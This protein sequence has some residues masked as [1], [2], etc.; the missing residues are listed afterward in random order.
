MQF[1]AGGLMHP[2]SITTLYGAP[3]IGKGWVSVWAYLQLIFEGYNPLILDFEGVQDE[4]WRRFRSMG[5][6]EPVAY[7]EPDSYFTTPYAANIIETVRHNEFTHVIIDSASAARPKLSDN[8]AGGS[9]ATIAMFKS[10]K[11]IDVPI[12]LIAHE[13]KQ[14]N[15]PIGSIHFRS[16]SRLV[17]Q[18][19]AIPNGLELRMT[20]ANDVPMSNVPVSFYL[21]D[22][23]IQR[24]NEVVEKV[25]APTVTESLIN[26]MSPSRSWSAEQMQRRLTEEGFDVS[27][28]KVASLMRKMYMDGK[29]IRVGRGRYAI[30]PE[31]DT[32]N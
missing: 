28:S 20:K 13:G 2:E 16:Q 7:I 31:G 10:L 14:A 9:D 21:V 18:A 6:R 15:G 17:W 22:G 23:V 12:L 8:D 29:L 25:S 1:V 30:P 32:L 3:G 5:Y 19:K 4:W 24:R 11:A 27:L 26:A